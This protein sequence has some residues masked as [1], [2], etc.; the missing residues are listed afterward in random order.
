M[1]DIIINYSIKIKG[2]LSVSN[3]KVPLLLYKSIFICRL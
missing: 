3:D 1:Q 2:A